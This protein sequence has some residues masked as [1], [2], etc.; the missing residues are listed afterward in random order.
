MI[1]EFQGTLNNEQEAVKAMTFIA[2]LNAFRT[3]KKTA[4]FSFMGNKASGNLEDIAIPPEVDDSQDTSGV[5]F[6]NQF[7]FNDTGIDAILRR[8]DTGRFTAEQLDNCVTPTVRDK[9]GLDIVKT[10][11]DSRFEEDLAARFDT[12]QTILEC[13]TSIY[14]YIFVY[15][16]SQHRDF[17]EKM[18]N[19]VDKIVIVAPQGKVQPLSETVKSF[20]KKTGLIITNFDEN[21]KYSLRVLKKA[22][23]IASMTPLPYN[24]KFSD[25]CESGAVIS[26]AM[27]NVHPDKSD[28][29]LDLVEQAKAAMHFID[30]KAD[31][32][33]V[34]LTKEIEYVK[35]QPFHNPVLRAY[36]MP[37]H[38]ETKERITKSG[39][40]GLHKNVDHITSSTFEDGEPCDTKGLVIEDL[41]HADNNFAEDTT[42]TTPADMPE[43]STESVSDDSTDTADIKN[44]DN[45]PFDRDKI[46]GT[47]D[48][49]ADA[50]HEDDVNNTE[51]VNAVNT[52]NNTEAEE[53]DAENEDTED[54]TE[55][56][57]YP[58]SDEADEDDLLEKPVFDDL[59]TD[60]DN[61]NVLSVNDKEDT[62]DTELLAEDVVEDDAESTETGTDDLMDDTDNPNTSDDDNEEDIPVVDDYTLEDVKA[63]LAEHDAED[64]HTNSTD[65]EAESFTD[66]DDTKE[67]TATIT[68]ENEEEEPSSITPAVTDVNNELD[69]AANNKLDTEEPTATI[70]DDIDEDTVNVENNAK[71][72]ETT[73]AEEPTATITVEDD[74]STPLVKDKENKPSAPQNEEVRE[75]VHDMQPSE[76]TEDTDVNAEDDWFFN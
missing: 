57:E 54:D 74:D 8:A 48:E 35:A 19:F 44:A 70:T 28:V 34:D 47:D 1:I 50:S 62:E 22:Y 45:L 10:T 37:V 73:P 27:K 55:D 72:E 14:D 39:F 5:N 63:S 60:A 38:M 30:G 36:M 3:N 18:G 4:L 7:N 41:N 49:D 13:A 59:S 75:N 6:A 9:N 58:E 76:N 12:I 31:D 23:G 43:E 56:Y 61:E 40:L 32:T 68:V 46:F 2:A 33:D 71:T 24:I 53:T 15:V 42:D 16:S 65:I 21:S 17:L 66:A 69:T 64:T 52:E 11:K 51:S 25:A 29:N 26:F 20:P 67:P